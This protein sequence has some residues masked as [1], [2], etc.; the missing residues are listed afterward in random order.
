MAL[1]FEQRVYVGGMAT[2]E[3]ARRFLPGSDKTVLPGRG[4]NLAEE[5]FH[6]PVVVHVESMEQEVGSRGFGKHEYGT[7]GRFLQA[8]TRFVP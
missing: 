2:L 7:A 6:R 1:V 4:G 3:F 8:R 5:V